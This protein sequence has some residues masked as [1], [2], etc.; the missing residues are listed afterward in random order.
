MVLKGAHFVPK[1][2]SHV[3]LLLVGQKV[4]SSHVV[5]D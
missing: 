2:I 4:A 5:D 1:I 3:A